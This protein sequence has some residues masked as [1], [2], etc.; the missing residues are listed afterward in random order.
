MVVGGRNESGSLL[1]S[2]ESFNAVNWVWTSQ[3]N[4]TVGKS[5]HCQVYIIFLHQYFFQF[6]T[7]EMNRFTTEYLEETLL[8]IK[9]F[10]G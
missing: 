4:I 9:I 5:M 8:Q 7:S 6:T 10:G 1:D 2:V 3:N